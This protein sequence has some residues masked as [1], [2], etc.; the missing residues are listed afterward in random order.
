LAP[1]TNLYINAWRCSKGVKEIADKNLKNEAENIRAGRRLAFNK[2]VK[3][4]KK[5]KPKFNKRVNKKKNQ[6]K[7]STHA[8]INETEYGS[9]N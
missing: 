7:Q 9:K 5:D 1:Y 4:Y 3:L 2:A 8:P 6:E